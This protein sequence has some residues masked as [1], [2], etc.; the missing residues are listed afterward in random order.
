V[1]QKPTSPLRQAT[2][3]Q[4]LLLASVDGRRAQ[5]LRHRLGGERRFRR[6]PLAV[7]RSPQASYC[8]RLSALLTGSDNQPEG[9]VMLQGPRDTLHFDQRRSIG[10]LCSYAMSRTLTSLSAVSSRL[11][12]PSFMTVKVLPTERN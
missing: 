2:A 11:D 8:R 12:E 7:E 6:R 10:S 3:A 4:V 9:D 5:I 1:K